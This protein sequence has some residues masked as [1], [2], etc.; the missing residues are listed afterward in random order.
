MA[1]NRNVISLSKTPQAKDDYADALDGVGISIDVLG[2]DLGGAAKSLY[3]LDQSNLFNVATMAYSQLGAT[4]QIIDGQVFYDPSG[5]RA[6]EALADGETATDLFTYAIRLANGT[7]STATAYVT[8]AG[9]ND[10]PVAQIIMNATNE[11]GPSVTL[12]ADFTDADTNDTHSFSIDTTGTKGTV[13]NNNDGTFSYNPNGQFESLAAGETATDTFTYTVTDDHGLS[14]TQ[15]ATVTITGQNDA[16]VAVADANAG[17]AVTEL[18]VNP[19]DTPFVGDPSATGN[20]LENDSAG[21]AGDSK[22]VVGVAAGTPGDVDGGV[23]IPVDGTYGSL[24]VGSDGA[25]TYTL[26]NS[27]PATQTLGQDAPAQDIFTYTMSDGHGGT[28]TTTLTIDIAGTNDQP[29]IT[30]AVGFGSITEDQ[31]LAGSSDPAP[32]DATL[33]TLGTVT[34]LD[35]DNT[36]DAHIISAVPVESGYLGTFSTTITHDT[37][38]NGA[39][40]GDLIGTATWNFSVANSDLQFLA[41]DETRTQTYAVTTADGHGGTASQQVI[42]TLTG[43]NDAPEVEPDPSSASI[44]ETEGT[45]AAGAQLAVAGTFSFAD[46]DL[47]DTH[48]VQSVS[49][50]APSSSTL[51]LG[52]L[53]ANVTSDTA[54][55]VGGEV[56]WS[57]TVD[58]AAV[59]F[60]G[61]GQQSTKRSR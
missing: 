34:F 32:L 15:T 29:V 50:I 61:S 48:A 56:S 41:Q 39:S 42:V 45:P 52:Q 9:S 21:D 12:T 20:V 53:I 57:Y 19:S 40:S 17:D 38:H 16:P 6:I 26:D 5:V 1:T 14:S 10:A 23:G 36:D 24:V 18:G 44:T 11:D 25:W 7:I 43:T 27:R 13:V 51:P 30:E 31:P 28:S 3:S 33:S 58:A 37:D 59:E 46:V 2:N 22:T 60:L 4:I 55:G 54:N 8:V 47:T 49:F 35:A